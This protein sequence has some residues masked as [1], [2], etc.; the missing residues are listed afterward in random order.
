MKILVVG[1]AG[2]IGSTLVPALLEHGYQVDVVDLMWFGNHLPK[3]IK[4]I[5]KK[6]FSK[7]I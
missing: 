1:G 4:I 6:I 7:F 5:K 3:E 2:Y